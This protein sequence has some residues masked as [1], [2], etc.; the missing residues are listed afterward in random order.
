MENWAR[1]IDF[2]SL[3]NCMV[4]KINVVIVCP[5]PRELYFRVDG[6]NYESLREMASVLGMQYRNREVEIYSENDREEIK[7]SHGLIQLLSLGLIQ[8]EVIVK[9]L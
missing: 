4:E 5:D 7:V 1:F 8:R 9:D 3:L 2:S 6:K